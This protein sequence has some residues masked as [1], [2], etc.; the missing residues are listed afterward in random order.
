MNIIGILIAA[1][2]VGIVGIFVSVPKL[3]FLIVPRYVE[4]I[5]SLSGKWK[6]L[7]GAHEAPFN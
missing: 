4:I 6:I 3:P 1:A 2:V 5:W 7:R